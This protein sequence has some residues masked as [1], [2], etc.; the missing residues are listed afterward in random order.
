MSIISEIIQFA[1]N[2]KSFSRKELIDSLRNQLPTVL[3]KTVSQQ[4]GRLAK[5]KRLVRLGRGVYA[6]PET[7]QQP[8]IPVVFDKLKQLNE[9][10][11]T[12]FP[13]VSYCLWSSNILFSYMHHIP[14]LNFI[15][16]DVESDAVESV[17]NFLSDNNTERVFLRPNATDFNRYIAGTES[18]IIRSLISESP[19]QIIEKVPSP[20]IEKI[21]VD[22]VGDVEFE[23]L[24]GTEI[25]Y[26]YHNVI[27]RHTFNKNKLLR[28][29][30]R[31]GRRNEVEHL[32]NN[33]L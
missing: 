22:V 13:F 2:G 23:F 29:A 10:I 25:T 24:Q 27:E 21:L 15:C 16:M 4:L 19:L 12:Q 20:T 14:N 7:L 3:Q 8:F 6:L 1:A 9:Q 26:F 17:F 33:A 5:S 18:I 32:Y 31:R 28:Y 11:K 30:S